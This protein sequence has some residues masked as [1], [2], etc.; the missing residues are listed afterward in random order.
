M[1]KS[2]LLLLTMMLAGL[3][4]WANPV[5]EANVDALDFGQVNVGYPVSKTVRVTGT[6]LQDNITLAID[7]RY[8]SQYDVN[9]KTITPEKAA[10]GVSVTVKYS[11]TSKWSGSAN[12]VLTSGNADD[13]VIPITADPLMQSTIYG[14]NNQRYYAA[15]VGGTDSSVEIAYFADVEVP[16]DPD[17]PVDRGAMV[18]LVGLDGLLLG[19][20]DVT[21]EGDNCFRAMIVKSSGIVNTCNVRISYTPLTSGTHHATLN[22]YCPDAGVPLIVV[23]LNGSADQPNGD[24]NADGLVAIND[25]TNMIDALLMEGGVRGSADMNGDHM[26]TITDVTRLIDVLLGGE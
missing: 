5:I 11:P 8:A 9:P 12:L 26:L 23:H 20:Y 14:Y 15:S 17:L 10:S 22:L 4:A 2:F 16:T 21:I 6:D 24:A 13:L 18:D 25:V 3:F 1:K 7:G 19:N